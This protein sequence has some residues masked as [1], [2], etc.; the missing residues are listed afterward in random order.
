M[1]S[2]FLKNTNSTVQEKNCFSYPRSKISFVFGDLFLESRVG[3]CSFSPAQ[4]AMTR[5]KLT[6]GVRAG[7][8]ARG[9]AAAQNS[10]W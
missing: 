4:Q 2:I 7:M 10:A 9:A 3:G 6:I 5:L 1:Y 8:G